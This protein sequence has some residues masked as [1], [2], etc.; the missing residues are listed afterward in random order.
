MVLI[1]WDRLFGTFRAEDLPEPVKYG[2]TRQPED[3]RTVNVIFHE[4]RALVADVQKAPGFSNKLKYLFN[5]PGWSH[6]GS[7]QTA[8]VL[9]QQYKNN[10]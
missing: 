7:T 2:L 6:D 10:Q 4:W 9:Q 5:P 8:R 3:M 1:I